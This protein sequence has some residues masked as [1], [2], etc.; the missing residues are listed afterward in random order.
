MAKTIKKEK[1]KKYKYIVL[2]EHRFGT[3]TNQFQSSIKPELLVGSYYGEELEIS[4][5][6]AKVIET[7]GIDFEP[8]RGESLYI[9]TFDKKIK[10]IG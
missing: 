5:E 1:V 4:E 7:V 9:E 6:L 8:E 10:D 3:D 2:H